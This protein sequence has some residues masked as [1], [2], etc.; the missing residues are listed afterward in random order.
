MCGAGSIESV[1]GRS[2]GPTHWGFLLLSAQTLADEKFLIMERIDWYFEVH[3]KFSGN[4][5]GFLDG[6]LQILSIPAV[7]SIPIS[8]TLVNFIP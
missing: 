2:T 4:P 7:F 5:V 6:F 3:C 8:K 1:R